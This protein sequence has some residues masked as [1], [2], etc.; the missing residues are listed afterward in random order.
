[1]S[2]GFSLDDYVPVSERIAKFY[3]A[4]PEGR[5][6]TEYRGIE[7]VGGKTF[8]V[9]AATVWRDKS[10]A[11]HWAAATGLAWEPFP[12]PTP[13]TR[14][15]ELMNAETSAVGRALANAGIEVRRGISSREDVQNRRQEPSWE[16]EAI[17]NINGRLELLPKDAVSRICGAATEKLG[18]EVFGPE[19]TPPSWQGWWEK[20]L[21]VEEA[22]A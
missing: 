7:E 12:G 13:F 6:E 16:P 14:D 2:G 3:E 5:I 9:V 1:M 22:K 21:S 10:Q 15:S 19:H 4:H 20:A 18:D 17:N 8:V 11:L